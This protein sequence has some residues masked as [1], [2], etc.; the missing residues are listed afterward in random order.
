MG[1]I[2]RD[3]SLSTFTKQS[4]TADGGTSFT[5]NQGVGDSSSILVSIG[6]IVQQPDVAYSA[7]GTALTFTSAPTNA[8]PIW[9][10]YLGK[11]LTVSTETSLDEVDTQAGV[12]NGSATPITLDNSVSSV[13]DIIV[14]LNGI[15]QKPSTDYTV[16]GTTLT[17][18]TA[19]SSAMNILVYYLSLS[20]A[21]NTPANGSVST[22][23]Q[24]VS[25]GT[26]P[27]WN[28][29]NLINTGSDAT[30]AD[31]N[32]LIASL[33]TLSF[34]QNIDHSTAL[35]NMVNGW[36]TGT[37]ATD[38]YAVDGRVYSDHESKINL[39]FFDGNGDGLTVSDGTLGQ[40]DGKSFIISF[41]MKAEM[42][43]GVQ[44]TMFTTDN[45][46]LQV[47]RS[48]DNKLGLVLE[49]SSA[50]EIAHIKSTRT[51]TKSD[52]LVHCLIAIDMA[53]TTVQM[54]INGAA[55]ETNVVLTAVANDNIDFTNNFSIAKRA[56]V[57]YHGLLGQ[58][59]LTQE[60]LDIS[61]SANRQK[62]YKDG[63]VFLG[64]NG[65]KPTG[66]QP[67]IYLNNMYD[68]FQNN[69]GS[70]GNFS[71][72]G[73]LIYGGE[74]ATGKG[75]YGYHGGN[76]NYYNSYELIDFYG[77]EN[78]NSQSN[79]YSDLPNGSNYKN[80]Q[81]IT[82]A[83]DI[84]V[85][86]FSIWTK[87]LGSPTGN[88]YLSI[89]GVTGT[90]GTNAVPDDNIIAS[91][92]PLDVGS[93]TTSFV[94]RTFTFAEPV[95]LPAGDYSFVLNYNGGN[96]SNYFR[97]GVDTSSPTH[98]GTFAQKS[99]LSGQSWVA[100]NNI[101]MC[102][103]LYGNRDIDIITK[104]TD[105]LSTTDS[106]AS[107]PTKG[108]IEALVD[109]RIINAS[110]QDSSSS[111]HTIPHV[112]AKLST[113][114]KKF[115]THSIKFDG[116]DEYVGVANS[117]DWAFSGDF[118]AECWFYNTLSNSNDHLMGPANHSSGAGWGIYFNGTGVLKFNDYANSFVLNNGDA[119][120]GWTA[121]TWNHVAVVR[122]GSTIK[123]YLNGT[124][125][126]SGSNNSALTNSGNF[127]IGS[128]NGITSSMHHNGYI[129][130]VRLSNVARYT[131][132]FTP[133]TTAFTSDA[134]TKLLIHGDEVV[135][136]PTLNTHVIGEMSRDGGTTWSPTTLA[137]SSTGINGATTEIFSGDVDFTGD[138][139][140]TNVV[141]RIRTA[142][143]HYMKVDGISVNWS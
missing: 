117:S 126:Y 119:N 89:C 24:F 142:K 23:S 128:D 11:E 134:N 25:S 62:Y 85:T 86:R 139:S 110:I 29:S 5:L 21:T 84:T 10:V 69:S 105:E 112:T 8:Y 80:A 47:Y 33:A 132:A 116:T 65:E 4:I 83:S 81:S 122:S 77:R 1:Y 123:L 93:L 71:V 2:G 130:E 91:A 13:N 46:R 102:F 92:T 68:S 70:G 94:L 28:G 20:G 125:K 26:W 88:A 82:F 113:V 75:E 133:S 115:G 135:T 78:Q 118:T 32:A 121:N 97:V 96:S 12:G 109:D 55:V 35:L 143:K 95:H 6:G 140:G 98:A 103:Y 67:R 59:Y 87:K 129:D 48:T 14:T 52:G 72:V 37:F 9:V 73:E 79:L 74:I 138:P 41:Y 39:S 43:D 114:Q 22:A 66:N 27:A 124:E 36:S 99:P 56:S 141:G 106:P 137:R 111:S 50:T 44:K 58:I 3:N 42:D 131:S 16:S 120:T 18:T 34:L 19:P 57:Y 15:A 45:N 61:N 90:P 49:N 40:S 136:Y 101:D 63:P 104:G 76:D 60:Y 38:G 100:D 53:N 127:G 64:A 30:Q 17:F 54:S 7:S 51:I 107:A 108:H 31:I